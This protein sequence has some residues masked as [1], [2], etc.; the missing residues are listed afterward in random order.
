[1]LAGPVLFAKALARS[2]LSPSVRQF[3]GRVQRYWYGYG[4]RL[5]PQ[6]EPLPAE[7][8]PELALMHYAW[9]VAAAS[10]ASSAHVCYYSMDFEGFPLPGERPW[11]PRWRLLSQDVCWRGARVL[12]LGCHL[13]LLGTFALRA[14]AQ[15]AVGVDRHSGL[16]QANQLVQ[17]AFRISYRTMQCD[18]DDPNPWEDELAACRPTIVTALSVLHWVK[19][20]ERFLRFLGRFATVLFEGHDG[21]AVECRRLEQAGFTNI[22][23]VGRSEPGRSVFLAGKSPCVI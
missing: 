12:E 16:L 8:S 21:D 9:Q 2:A 13:G 20:R 15:D 23:F 3:V 10:E 14:G 11:Q 17:R 6:M 1:M 18:F 22:A 19:D 4:W 5:P 7:A